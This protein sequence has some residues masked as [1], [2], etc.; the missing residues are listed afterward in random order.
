MLA[1][2]E[3]GDLVDVGTLGGAGKRSLGRWALW[4]LP[5]KRIL[6]AFDT[7]ESGRE[8]AEWWA[9]LGRRFRA[10]QVPSGADLTDYHA[11]GGDLRAWLSAKLAGDRRDPE[12]TRKLEEAREWAAEAEAHALPCNGFPS[13]AAW[14]ADTE[15]ALLAAG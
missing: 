5:Y 9:N 3:L 12:T 2:Q 15:A 14:L 11:S 13:W 6:A 4:L 1:W 8:G 7:D 10:L